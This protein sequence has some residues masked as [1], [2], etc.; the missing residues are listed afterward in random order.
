MGVTDVDTRS[1]VYSLGVLLYEL[2]TGTLP[3]DGDALSKVSFDEMRRIIREEEPLHPSRKV[4]TLRGDV[5]STVSS[6]RRSDRRCLK[7]SLTTELDWIV[8][9]ALEKDR[10]RRYESASALADDIERYLSDEPIQARPASTLYR[11]GKFTRRHRTLVVSAAAVLAALCIGLVLATVG[12][13]TAERR[14]IE[15]T[16]ERENSQL[17]SELLK[18]MYPT[19]WG[20]TTQGR[21]QTVYDSIEQL[22]TSLGDRLRNRPSVEIEVRK[23]FGSFYGSVNELEK[24][25]NHLN[26]ALD[27]ALRKYGPTHEIVGEIYADLAGLVGWYGEGPLDAETILSQAENA[28]SIYESLGRDAPVQA[29]FAKHFCLSQWPERKAEAE[30]ACR[31]YVRLARK[32]HS[33][34]PVI[35]LWDLGVLLM[36]QGRFDEAQ[37]EFENALRVCRAED[38]PPAIMGTVLSGL[39]KNYRRQK[40]ITA[41][42]DAFLEAWNLY[43]TNNLQDEPRGH[44]IGLELAEVYFASGDIDQAFEQVETIEGLAKR[45]ERFELLAEC[46]F[47]KGWFHYK[48][49][50]Y[51]EAELLFREA[52]QVARDHV[53]EDHPRYG[54]PAAY[55]A[56]I[57]ESKQRSLEAEPI[58]R[59]MRTQTKQR[60]IDK[61]IV[62]W[63]GDWAYVRA[64]L[65]T[66]GSDEDQLRD[67]ARVANHGLDFINA[68]PW[69]WLESAFQL[70]LAKIHQRRGNEEAAIRS[71]RRGLDK[72][73]E[74]LATY[75][76]MRS[77]L[78][79]T[80]EELEIAL[81]NLL[82]DSAPDGREQAR[83]VFEEGVVIR[84]HGLG[85][86]HIQTALAQLRL[87]EFLVAYAGENERRRA[88]ELI[89]DAYRKLDTHSSTAVTAICRRAALQLADLYDALGQ[90]DEAA[91]WRTKLD[92]L[93]RSPESVPPEEMDPGDLQRRSA[94]PKPPESMGQIWPNDTHTVS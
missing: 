83:R 74:P 80:R 40:N 7:D 36:D 16:R 63:I 57:L 77:D 28:I 34:E 93:D 4:Q 43:M 17:L 20:V 64:T 25:R 62:Y 18:D 78:P 54:W 12:Y 68:W 31:Q 24:A 52:M 47:L 11:M 30:A 82:V 67:A 6:R 46:L 58:Y 27:L 90:P 61:P 35:P 53:G 49:E 8:M 56:F 23:T 41:A 60:F 72:A 70:E 1:D 59:R 32:T 3:F 50:N 13:M 39:G 85:I 33:S 69:P 44:L 91:N 2:L 71:F 87:G 94:D 29:W 21:K 5:A 51:G 92:Q 79:T 10:N 66:C 38:F 9:K 42:K 22:S 15:I 26:V 86:D 48:L 55:L 37:I 75:V 88:G 84:E 65:G 19:P 76:A 45:L 81:A 73:T 14:L 89:R